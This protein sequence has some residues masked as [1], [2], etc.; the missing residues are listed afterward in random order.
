MA[1]AFAMEPGIGRPHRWAF[2]ALRPWSRPSCR[3][4]ALPW[5][6]ANLRPRALAV[7]RNAGSSSQQWGTMIWS[8][9]DMIAPTSGTMNGPV[10]ES[11]TRKSIH[12]NVGRVKTVPPHEATPPTHVPILGFEGVR[13]VYGSPLIA[14]PVHAQ[15][16]RRVAIEPR[17]DSA[18]RGADGED[19][20]RCAVLFRHQQFWWRVFLQSLCEFLSAMLLWPSLGLDPRDLALDLDPGRGRGPRVEVEIPGVEGEAPLGSRVLG[21]RSK[22]L[23]SRSRCLGSR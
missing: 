7:G 5:A 6:A 16:R 3:R 20:D 19:V 2:S 15:A 21:S 22:L 17:G 9:T 13:G 8:S 4:D 18:D 11:A 1:F 10:M 14:F 23:G 12:P